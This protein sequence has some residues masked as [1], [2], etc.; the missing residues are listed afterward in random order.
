MS[1]ICKFIV[2]GGDN[3]QYYMV[4]QLHR[5]GYPVAVYGLDMKQ[6]SPV[7]YEASSIKEAMS[8]GNIVIGPVPFS[9][10]GCELCSE[11]SLSDLN[12]SSILNLLTENH[13]LYGGCLSKSIVEYCGEKH[14]PYMD[15][16]NLEEVSIANAVATAEGTILEAIQRSPLTLHQSNCL[17]FGFGR[18]ARILADKLKGLNARVTISARSKEAL[19]MAAAYG[20]DTYPLA[21]I[22]KYLTKFG[23]IFNTIPSL[24]MDAASLSYVQKDVTIIDIASAPGGINYDYCEQM[25]LNASLCLGLP[26]KY[27]P[28][29][30]AEILTNAL[31]SDISSYISS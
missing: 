25:H 27:A 15:F 1:Q 13:R 6:L 10:N 7:I 11:S 31:L 24:I 21:D 26:G 3:R 8:F 2:L 23:F 29:T 20:F 5:L 12:I 22:N 9:K 28:K 16:L 17:I 14:I 30:S 4:E 19:S 18:C